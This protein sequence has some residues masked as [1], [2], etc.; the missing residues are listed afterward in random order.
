MKKIAKKKNPKIAKRREKEAYEEMRK[1]NNGPSHTRRT[2]EERENKKPCE[3]HNEDVDSPYTWICH[4]LRILVHI[5]RRLRHYIHQF[6]LH[7][8]L[9]FIAEIDLDDDLPNFYSISTLLKLD[10]LF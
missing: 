10:F 6:L 3:E 9:N 1:M 5:F 2:T 4:P 7:F 8:H